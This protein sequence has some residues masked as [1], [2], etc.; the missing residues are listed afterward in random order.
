MEEKRID[1][2]INDEKMVFHTPIYDIVSKNST[3]PEGVTGDYYVI[4]APDWVVVLP[5]LE[6]RF[7]M[8]RQWR[9]GSASVTTEFPGGVC[10]PKEDPM[11]TAARELSE[12]TAYQAGKITCL[13]TFSPNPAL[14]SNRFHIFLAEEL[15]PLPE[16]KLDPDE[17]IHVVEIPE[18]EVLCGA[19]KGELI[20]AFMGTVLYMYLQY[21]KNRETLE[22]LPEKKAVKQ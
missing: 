6:G 15:T 20:H 22:K 8:V 1:W 14:F 10:D 9:H 18:E 16:Q 7:V 12:E 2:K 3:A 19:G 17:F 21:K 5:V 11:V 4:N 13:G